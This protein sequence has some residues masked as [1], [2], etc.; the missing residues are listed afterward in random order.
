MSENSS[1]APDT[2]RPDNAA[3]LAAAATAWVA[4]AFCLVVVGLLLANA[5]R[6][7][8]YDPVAPA[9]IE[10]LKAQ[11]GADRGN[12][13]LRTQIRDLDIRLRTGYFTTRARAVHGTYLLAIGLIVFLIAT[14]LAAKLRAQLPMPNPEAAGRSW[15]DAALSLRS[16]AALGLVMAGF[17][18]AMMILGRHDASAEYIRA[19]REM[20]DEPPGVQVAQVPDPPP[21]P[22]PVAA[23]APAPPGG[24]VLPP[25]PPAPPPATPPGPVR[26]PG[27]G[28]AAPPPMTQPPPAPP[29]PEPDKPAPEEKPAPEPKGS[30]GEKPSKPEPDGSPGAPH[31]Q[32]GPG[33]APAPGPAA[34]AVPKA[35]PV[36][37]GP[38]AGLT[39]ATQF[40]VEW[41]AEGGNPRS[42][43]C[44]NTLSMIVPR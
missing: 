4:L 42:P 11:L 6:A 8:T 38:V 7:K 16:V 18:L 21:G 1:M 34:H 40:P 3:Y 17:L 13:E 12:D 31:P 14:H 43:N 27:A 44:C 35:W 10:L 25:A 15:V 5:I 32:P 20:S 33:P 39:E 2:P 26:Q 24:S 41:D 29:A 37:R 30:D 19:A 28:P 23:D 36:F 9:Q 22:V